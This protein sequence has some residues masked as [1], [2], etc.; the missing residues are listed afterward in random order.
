[1]VTTDTV[2]YCQSKGLLYHSTTQEQGRDGSLYNTVYIISSA[3]D[4]GH[5]LPENVR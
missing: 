1:M 4:I 5:E 2:L 3:H